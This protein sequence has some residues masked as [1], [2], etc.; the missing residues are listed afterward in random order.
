VVVKNA[1]KKAR[2]QPEL[3]Q[4]VAAEIGEPAT[5]AAFEKAFSEDSRPASQPPSGPKTTLEPATAAVASRFAPEVLERVERRLA[6]HIGGIARVLVKR[7]AM[8]ARTEAE[9]YLL[10]ADEIEDK[11][12]KKAFIRKAVSASGKH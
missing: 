12:Q 7:A 1:A 5:R 6:E 10:L 9:L 2:T 11:E 8:K 3:I 4:L